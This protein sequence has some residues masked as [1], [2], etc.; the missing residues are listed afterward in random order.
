MFKKPFSFQGRIRRTEYGLSMI[1]STFSWFVILLF[2]VFTFGIGFFLF[3]PLFIFQLAQGTKRCHDMGNSGWWQLI[4][5]YPIIM[6]FQ[7]GDPGPNKYGDNPKN[8]TTGNNSYYNTNK[9]ALVIPEKCP[10]CKNPNSNR[11]R[12]CEWC[13]GQ[14][15]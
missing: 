5:F 6:L 11:I 7:E 3:V 14:I 9:Q 8:V 2:T 4:P 13:G 12:L 1:I 10:H 15:C